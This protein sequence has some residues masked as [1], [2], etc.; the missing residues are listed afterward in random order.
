LK[1]VSAA[2]DGLIAV[3]RV[4]FSVRRGGIIAIVGPNGAGKTTLLKLIN[5]LL[6]LSGGEIWFKQRRL[7]RTAPHRIASF[8]IIQVF[9]DIQL[10]SNMSVMDNVMVGCHVRSK[11]G[12]LSTG[13]RLPRTKAEEG[14]IFETAMGKLSLVGLEQKAFAA[15]SSLS[16]GQQ[17][18]LGLARALAAGPELLL[19]D[20]PYGG[21]M[22]DEIQK[23]SQLLL[24]LQHQGITILMVEQ[25]IDVVMGIANQV[26]VLNY[27][28]NIAQGTPSE[29]QDNEQVVATYL[30]GRPVEGKGS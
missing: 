11:A 18:L 24:E 15:T 8:G 9:Q 12:F 27:G 4:S 28:E 30:G 29:I 23:I 19:L 2:F 17:K 3:N 16:W 22:A 26:I 14:N 10:F 25:L 5:G 1:G 6:P 13:L 20:E 7:D 21:L